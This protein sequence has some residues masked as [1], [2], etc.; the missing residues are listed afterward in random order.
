MWYHFLQL[1]EFSQLFLAVQIILVVLGAADG[2]ENA[3]INYRGMK[4][5]YGLNKWPVC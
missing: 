4:G 1:E 5:L 2:G 3:V